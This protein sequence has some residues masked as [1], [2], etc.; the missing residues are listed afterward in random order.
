MCRLRRSDVS[1][2]VNRYVKR[3]ILSAVNGEL[4][5]LPDNKAAFD[6]RDSLSRG[7]LLPLPPLP[8]VPPPT[9]YN[10]YIFARDMT[11]LHQLRGVPDL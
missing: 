5:D 4:L 3:S 10:R 9:R 7:S 6:V 8:P 1:A 11:S 2:L